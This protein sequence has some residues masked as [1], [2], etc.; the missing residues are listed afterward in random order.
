M[1]TFFTLIFLSIAVVKLLDYIE[2]NEQAIAFFL[3]LFV[4]ASCNGWV[5]SLGA[6]KWR[7][8]HLSSL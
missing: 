7:E 2:A 3:H 1:L 4:L 6:R 5:R 8:L